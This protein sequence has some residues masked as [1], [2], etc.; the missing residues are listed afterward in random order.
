MIDM[1]A[2][3][4]EIFCHKCPKTA[5]VNPTKKG[6]TRLPSGWKRAFGR[7]WCDKCWRDSFV[8]R[9]ITIPIVGP[10]D[11]TWPE[12]RTVLAEAW[13]AMRAASNWMLDEMYARDVRRMP[14]MVKM[15]KQPRTYLYPEATKKFCPM[16]A[17]QTLAG[18][19]QAIGGKYRALRYEVIWTGEASLPVYRYPAPLTVPNQGWSMEFSDAGVPIIAFRLAGR[20]LRDHILT[21]AEQV[22][23]RRNVEPPRHIRNAKPTWV[24][25][26]KPP[27]IIVNNGGLTVFI[28]LRELKAAVESLDR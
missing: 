13:A 10:V 1:T 14:G 26:E 4:K 22:A 27:G 17:A 23:A 5:D 16:I 3:K 25:R 2:P 15:P 6:T 7:V 19:E 11:A 18:L 21:P 9:A 28:P 8:L 12:F 24:V 20:R